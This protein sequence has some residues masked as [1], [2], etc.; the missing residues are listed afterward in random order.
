MASDL[1]RACARNLALEA[2]AREHGRLI[3]EAGQREVD[4][5]TRE[6]RSIPPGQT[7]LEPAL[8][9]RYSELVAQ[10]AQLLQHL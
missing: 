4:R 7:L 5:I 1:Q 6:L 2:Q 8:A 3:R 9:T 10:R